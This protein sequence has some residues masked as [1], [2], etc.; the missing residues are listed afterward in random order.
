MTL[1]EKVDL[2]KILPVPGK[3]NTIP[4]HGKKL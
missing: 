2:E 4:T 3:T 1:G